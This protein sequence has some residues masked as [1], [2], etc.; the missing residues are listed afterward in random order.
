MNDLEHCLEV[1]SRSRQH[2]FTFDVE[3]LGNL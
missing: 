3:Y 1:V 2:C